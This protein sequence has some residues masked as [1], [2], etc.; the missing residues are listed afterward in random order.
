ML[1]YLTNLWG[2]SRTLGIYFTITPSS[3]LVHGTKVI[4]GIAGSSEDLIL[5]EKVSV[6]A[7]GKV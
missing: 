5:K 6:G 3:A 4:I 7:V 2:S 1:N